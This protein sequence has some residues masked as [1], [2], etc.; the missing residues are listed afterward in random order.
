MGSGGWKKEA[1]KSVDIRTSLGIFNTKKPTSIHNFCLLS[2]IKMK[3]ISQKVPVW[4][5]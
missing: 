3:R 1:D 4:G 5:L 2:V